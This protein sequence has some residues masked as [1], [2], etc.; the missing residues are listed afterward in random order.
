MPKP[1]RPERRA[2]ELLEEHGITRPPIPIDDLARKLGARLSFEAFSSNVS[3]L[4]YRDGLNV[5]MAINSSHATTRQRFTIAHEIGHLLLHEGPMFIDKTMRIDRR[6]E[7]AAL[8][9]APEEIEANRF[10]AAL[11]MPEH[12]V[13]EMVT[14]LGRGNP[15]AD[16]IIAALAHRFSVSSQAMEYRLVNIGLLEP[17]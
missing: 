3:G 1:T 10:A 13:L 11:L 2:Y 8:G 15:T 14:Q 6:D 17:N 7:N 12:M 16:E 4:L 5:T 9:T